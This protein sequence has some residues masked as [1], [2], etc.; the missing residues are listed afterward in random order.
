MMN[1]NR[2]AY[3]EVYNFINSLP[4]KEYKKI[5]N[6]VV[7]YI[8]WHRDYNYEFNYDCT[9]TVDEQNFSKE[10]VAMIM[11]LYLKYFAD[12]DERQNV[13][14]IIYKNNLRKNEELMKKYNPD[15]LFNNKDTTKTIKK[16]NNEGT[17]L[18]EYKKNSFFIRIKDFIKN[19]LHRNS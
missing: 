9:K 2:I 8:N 16:D 7:D 5:P 4:A 13:N 15:D 18:V 10:A 1:K 17:S 19:V 12:K 14:S 3:A 11:K 6:D